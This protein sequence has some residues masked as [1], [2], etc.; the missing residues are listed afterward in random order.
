VHGI[1]GAG[2][3]IRILYLVGSPQ[4]TLRVI[5]CERGLW[6]CARH[7]GCG[8]AFPGLVS[9]R[10]SSAGP[11]C[12]CLR[13]NQTGLGCTA[14]R[15]LELLS[16]SCISLAVLNRPCMSLPGKAPDRAWTALMWSSILLRMVKHP[17]PKG[18]IAPLRR[19]VQKYSKLW[20]VGS[21]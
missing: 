8:N 18:P 5:A 9:C 20:V 12:H 1:D 13:G 6:C 14:S 7:Q 16:G 21:G 17:T 3:P 4:P 15:A 2:T 19:C 11:P 10:Q